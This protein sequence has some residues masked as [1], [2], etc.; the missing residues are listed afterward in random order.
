[1][2]K[3][4]LLI[5]LIGLSFSQ[6]PSSG[7]VKTASIEPEPIITPTKQQKAEIEELI[8][9]YRLQNGKSIL[10]K[11]SY[12]CELAT[13]RLNEIKTDWPHDGFH[14]MKKEKYS[15]FGE[16]LGRDWSSDEDVMRA[17]IA[18][19]THND[20]LLGH[21]TNFCVSQEEGYYVLITGR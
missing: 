17:W 14:K 3:T 18:S 13:F 1:M 9:Q 7:E 20:I 19:P 21:W 15:S 5:I 6:I 12:L 8:N 10:R 2:K 11:D 16:N 4:L